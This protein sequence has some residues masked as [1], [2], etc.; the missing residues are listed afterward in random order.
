M[1][2]KFLTG[3][4]VIFLAVAGIISWAQADW[5]GGQTQAT[6]SFSP[7]EQ[8]YAQGQEFSLE[9]RMDTNNQD[10]VAAG[11][12]VDYDPDHFDVVGVNTSNSVL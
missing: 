11:A 4:I 9:V 7:Q 5:A 8:I 2:K 12:Y 1:V 6:L 10:V 3:I